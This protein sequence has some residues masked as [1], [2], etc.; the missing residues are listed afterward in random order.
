MTRNCLDCH[1]GHGGRTRFFLD[2]WSGDASDST[3]N[4]GASN[5]ADRPPPSTAG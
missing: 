5:G 1:N 4:N 3:T 2:N